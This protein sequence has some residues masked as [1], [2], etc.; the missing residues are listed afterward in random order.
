MTRDTYEMPSP[1]IGFSGLLL[2]DA[3]KVVTENAICANNPPAAAYAA[4]RI[5]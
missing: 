3:A 4:E 2:W 1:N 5:Y